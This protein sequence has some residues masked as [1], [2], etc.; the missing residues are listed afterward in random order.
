MSKTMLERAISLS[1]DGMFIPRLAKMAA[2]EIRVMYEDDEDTRCVALHIEECI[3]AGIAAASAD[4][5]RLL[6]ACGLHDAAGVL[7]GD[8]PIEEKEDA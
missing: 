8:E 1:A 4:D 6:L 7:S 3:K 2:G 5:V